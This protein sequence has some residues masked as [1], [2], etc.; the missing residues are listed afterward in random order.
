[1][2]RR[3][4]QLASHLTERMLKLGPPLTRDLTVTRD[5]R[6]PMPDGVELLAD[7]WAPASGGD[8]LPVALIRSPSAGTR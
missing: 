5:L 8:G 2:K 7:R 4:P 6:A 3:N 1:M